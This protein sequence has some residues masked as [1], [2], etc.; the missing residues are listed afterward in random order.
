[1][2]RFLHRM[3][4]YGLLEITVSTAFDRLEAGERADPTTTRASKIAMFKMC[5]RCLVGTQQLS[6]LAHTMCSARAR[7]SK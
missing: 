7:G 4:Q 1:M 3:Q 6:A 5:G 2:L